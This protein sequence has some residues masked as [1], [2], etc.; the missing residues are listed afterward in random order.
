MKPWDDSERDDERGGVFIFVGLW[1]CFERIVFVACLRPGS[2]REI[3]PLHREV[4]AADDSLDAEAVLVQPTLPGFASAAFRFAG[5]PRQPLGALLRDA[6]RGERL[7]DKVANHD[8]LPIV[9]FRPRVG[10]VVNVN[11]PSVA[12]LLDHA[13]HHLRERIATLLAPRFK[14]LSVTADHGSTEKV[15]VGL[16]G[17]LQTASSVMY[18][19]SGS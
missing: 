19:P 13:R 10:R 1:W 14:V 8:W 12:V 18:F 16:P 5:R 4:P 2:D 3:E 9:S 11:E 6:N 17:C 15:K 7:L